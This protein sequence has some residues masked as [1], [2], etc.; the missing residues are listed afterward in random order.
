MLLSYGDNIHTIRVK[1]AVM[2]AIA[3]ALITFGVLTLIVAPAVAGVVYTLADAAGVFILAFIGN[4]VTFMFGGFFISDL[5]EGIGKIK[6]YE[7]E[8]AAA[9][10]READ[11]ILADYERRRNNP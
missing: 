4:L 8:E 11:R 1:V 2:K 6:V 10:Q 7:E 9:K 5:P 3:A